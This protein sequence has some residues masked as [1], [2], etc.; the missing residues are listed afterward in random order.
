MKEYFR[1]GILIIFFSKKIV[2]LQGDLHCIARMSTQ[3]HEFFVFSYLKT[4][5]KIFWHLVGLTCALEVEDPRSAASLSKVVV[6]EG[7]GF[8][9]WAMICK[10]Y[11]KLT[12]M[13]FCLKNVKNRKNLGIQDK[14]LWKR[15]S[16]GLISE[17]F[18]LILKI[19]SWEIREKISQARLPK[20]SLSLK[21]SQTSKSNRRFASH[22]CTQTWNFQKEAG[23]SNFLRL[24]PQVA[25]SKCFQIVTKIQ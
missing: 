22:A 14:K 7:R 25:R 6:P 5:N 15:I 24:F 10:K 2:K 9:F 19:F 8:T 11:W 21:P 17:I 12:W 1:F 18:L 23:N 3:F 13:S 20:L 16:W 4:K